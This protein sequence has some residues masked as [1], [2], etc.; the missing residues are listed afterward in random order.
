VLCLP[1]A[2][3]R[4]RRRRGATSQRGSVDGSQVETR[5]VAG[6]RGDTNVAIPSGLEEGEL[7]KGK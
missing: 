4:L 7:V 1:P 3:A 2:G 6:L 5:Q